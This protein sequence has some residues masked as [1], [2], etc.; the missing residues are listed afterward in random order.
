[1]SLVSGDGKETFTLGKQESAS[2]NP[3]SGSNDIPSVNYVYGAKKVDVLLQCSSEGDNEFQAFGEDPVNTF[4]FR[5][6]H[7]CACWN[8]C[9]SKSILRNL[10][11]FS[12]LLVLDTPLAINA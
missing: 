9:S 3:G 10:F 12:I 6:T 7:K 8:G 11:H 2:W 5:L 4:K 1:L